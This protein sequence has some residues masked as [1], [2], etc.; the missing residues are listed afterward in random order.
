MHNIYELE[1]QWRNYKTRKYLPHV[2]AVITTLFLLA[3]VFITITTPKKKE[4]QNVLKEKSTEYL[5]IEEKKPK[6]IIK[7][8][9]S[10]ENKTLTLNPSF[11]F[12]KNLQSNS[13]TTYKP[14][15]EKI[16]S[17]QAQDSSSIEEN[18]EIIYIEELDEKIAT[19]SLVK[20]ET[21]DDINHVIKR[22]E[23]NNNPALGLFIA[24]RYYKLK[25]YQKSYRYAFLTNDIDAD[26]EE[27]WMIFSKSLVKLGKKEIAIKALLK[28]IQQSNSNNAKILLENIG[29]GKFK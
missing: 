20:Q 24:K 19:I 27:A 17:Y 25:D 4:V 18:T 12:I 1:K 26:I 11:D 28:Y 3:Y 21:T 6:E 10:N 9:V 22:F 7:E 14:K 13:I 2:G 23:K 8:K 16:Q 15:A 29:T 5:A